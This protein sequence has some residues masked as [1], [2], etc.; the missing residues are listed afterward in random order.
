MGIYVLI[1][2]R[3]LVQA[4]RRTLLLGLA[5]AS[6]TMLL[7]MLLSWSSGISE[8]MVR[9][10]TALSS[11]H[12]NVGGFYKSTPSDTAPL[13]VDVAQV[14]TAVEKHAKNVDYIIT[15][16]RG[17][18]RLVSDSGSIQ[19]GIGGID[20]RAD[21]RFLEVVQLSAESEYLDDGRRQI[22]G[23]IDDLAKDNRVLLFVKQAKQLGV[24]VGDQLTVTIE[25]LT[26]QTNSVDVTVAAVA[27]DVGLLSGWNIYMSET[28]VR[29]I[30][31]L[32]D[33]AAGVIM[34][35]LK[36]ISEA[37]QAMKTI[38]LGLEKDGYKVMEH[39]PNPFWAKFDTVIAEDWVGQKLDLTTWR[40]EVNFLT[41]I[42][43]AIDSVSFL[44]I[45]I[46][47]VII[48][49]GIMNAMWI[50]VRERTNEIGTVRA[51]GMA[52]NRVLTLF[53]TEALLLG[54]ASTLLG[55]TLGA[56]LS[57]AIDALQLVV[58]SRAV[59]IML[60]SDT[61]HFSVSI[62]TVIGSTIAFTVIVGLAAI[63]PAYRASQLQPVT[64]INHVG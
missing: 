30:Y 59:Q 5:L 38:G 20:I 22:I 19:T 11:G 21:R 27:Q 15:R 50:S 18:A 16:Q 64:A 45:S 8:T 29:K 3:N 58:P 56:I 46:L 63:W 7:V 17:W 12:V 23:N 55:A 60:M 10:A 48:S 32:S 51:L 31:D 37:N 24:Q 40:D 39:D 61:L 36:D 34:V 47:V 6:V 13:V 49:I 41:W 57:L 1:A 28:S 9:S 43:R 35:Y 33:T 14:R 53:M 4:K 52:K 54:F 62:S 25:T 2:Y 42:L 44:L 26:G